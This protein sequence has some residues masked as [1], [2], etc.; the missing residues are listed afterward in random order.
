MTSP[1]CV[2]HLSATSHLSHA[3]SD[4]RLARSMLSRLEHTTTGEAFTTEH[5]ALIRRVGAGSE[6]EDR[7]WSQADDARARR[8]LRS[9]TAGD[10][11]TG[12]GDQ[13]TPPSK[14]QATGPAAGWTAIGYPLTRP[15][16]DSSAA[17]VLGLLVC[18]FCSPCA[19]HPCLCEC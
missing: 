17:W 12:V 7:A 6:G 9:E 13:P 15:V 5:E 10:G 3:N 11:G 16:F 4:T 14:K 8:L 18:R 2:N 1:F 19:L